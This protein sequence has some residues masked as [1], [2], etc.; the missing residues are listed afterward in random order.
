MATT[1]PTSTTA[2][3]GSVTVLRR[4]IVT[5]TGLGG[6]AIRVPHGFSN[7]TPSF[8]LPGMSYSGTSTSAGPIVQLDTSNSFGQGATVWADQTYV[9]LT[10]STA[11][12]FEILVN[13]G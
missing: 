3:G 8:V 11:G 5:V 9:Y 2:G 6:G 13:P 4:I 7:T 12:T 10:V 1:G